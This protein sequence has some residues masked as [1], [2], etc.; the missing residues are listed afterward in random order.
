M[1][2]F[3][4]TILTSKAHDLIAKLTA[5]KADIKFTKIA[6]SDCDYSA[7]T[8]EEIEEMVRLD[9]IRQEV[10]VNGAEII[11][12]STVSVTASLENTK[13]ITGYY[14]KAIGLY[15]NDGTS[16]ILYSVTIATEADYMPA[17][18]NIAPSGIDFEILTEVSNAENINIEIS[19]IANVSI[20]QFNDFKNNITTQLNTIEKI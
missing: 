4:R 19:D 8:V 1:A 13:L 12:S 11:N 17:F 18:N 15:A 5:G 6:T 10:L 7:L 14:I 3:K 2:K 16:E 9:N 20:A